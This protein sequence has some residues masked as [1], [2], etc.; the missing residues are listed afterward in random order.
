MKHLT[1]S[2][3]NEYLDNVLSA[4]ERREV[5]SHLEACTECHVRLNEIQFVFTSLAGLPKAQLTRDLS[6]SVLANLPLRSAR[7]WSPTFTAQV[8][9]ALGVFIWLSI[10]AV[11]FIPTK[12]PSFH[13]PQFVMPTLQ[14]AIP[15][16]RF[17]NLYSIF[18][19]LQ[20]P[21]NTL[22]TLFPIHYSLSFIS[23]LQLPTLPLAT[24]VLSAFILWMIGNTTLLR[25]H[26]EARK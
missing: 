16:L 3:L 25:N 22:L 19:T 5:E 12:L 11:K 4:P 6:A 8:G 23:S 15:D 24:A 2:Q 1:N 18:A 21:L 17:P 9:A 14:L 10:Q 7:L 26:H 20:S 13:F